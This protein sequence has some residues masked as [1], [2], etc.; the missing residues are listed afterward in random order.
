MLTIF[1][2]VDVKWHEIDVSHIYIDT[3]IF[4]YYR[5]QVRSLARLVTN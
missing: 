4:N 3:F 1:L 2:G 5:T